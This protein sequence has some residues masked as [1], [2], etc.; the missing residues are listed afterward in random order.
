M[1]LFASLAEPSSSGPENVTLQLVL[2]L[3]VRWL[4]SRVVPFR[5]YLF[6]FTSFVFKIF[7]SVCNQTYALLYVTTFFWDSYAM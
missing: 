6:W 4:L 7:S 5:I 2:G 1:I 3:C